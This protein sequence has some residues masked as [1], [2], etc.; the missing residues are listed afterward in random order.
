MSL[1][2]KDISLENKVKDQNQRHVLSEQCVEMNISSYIFVLQ[3]VKR[4]KELENSGAIVGDNQILVIPC[5]N[6]F[7]MNVGMKY[8][9]SDN[10]D[11]N[12]SFLGILTGNQQ[13]VW[14]HIYLNGLKDSA[15]ESIL[16]HFSEAGI[17]CHMCECLQ[18]ERKHQLASLFGLPYVLTSKQRNF[19][20]KTL[21]YNWQINGT[22]AFS[23]YSGE[24][25]NI[26]V[27]LPGSC[28][29]RA[30]LLDSNGYFK[31]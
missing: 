13:A 11:I 8:W 4:L 9:V 18:Q 22:D 25:D 6:N 14:Q 29:C 23:V 19:D 2:S 5:V 15:M 20:K 28:I 21:T 30:S 7:S 12:V 27:N 3:L 24:T 1:R 17:L 10:S 16:H 31:I 26:D